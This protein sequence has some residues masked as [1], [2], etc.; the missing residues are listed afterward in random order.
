MDVYDCVHVEL[1]LTLGEGCGRTPS[2]LISDNRGDSL[3]LSGINLLPETGVESRG[4][5]AAAGVGCRGV[6]ESPWRDW[7]ATVDVDC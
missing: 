6:G 4:R 7:L 5:V 1:V 2:S 3:V